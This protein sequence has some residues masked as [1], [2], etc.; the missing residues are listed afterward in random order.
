MNYQEYRPTP[1]LEKYIDAYWTVKTDGRAVPAFSRIIPDTCADI[2]INL[3]SAVRSD[4]DNRTTMQAERSYLVG[5]MTKYCDTLFDAEALL[6]GIR[7]KPFALN[8]LLGFPLAGATDKIFEVSNAEFAF[9]NF[10]P[11]KKI[12]DLCNSFDAWFVNR[13]PLNGNLSFNILNSIDQSKGL[14]TVSALAK[15]HFTTERQLERICE[16]RI[17]ITLKELCK[18]VRF[19]NAVRVLAK[20]AGNLSIDKIAFETGYYDHSHLSKEIKRYTGYNP[21][22]YL[23]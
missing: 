17:G 6:F 18:Q 14:I 9:R 7:F 20:Q 4:D 5:T 10:I 3:G 22:H 12:N 2:I 15:R 8:A 1:L 16:H 11:S 21:T 19:R 13:L 23:K